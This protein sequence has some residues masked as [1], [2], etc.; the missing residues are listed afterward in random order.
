MHHAIR[1]LR[2]EHLIRLAKAIQTEN[3][4]LAGRAALGGI[5]IAATAA[6]AQ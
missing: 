4:A 6:A 3:V 5:A 2:K 1:T